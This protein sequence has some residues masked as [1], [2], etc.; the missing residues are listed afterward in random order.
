MDEN[1]ISLTASRLGVKDSQVKATLELLEE[2]STIPFIARYRKEVTGNLDEEQI[3]SISE[4]Y[5]YELKLQTRKEEVKRLIKEKDKLTD[6]IAKA[7]DECKMLSEVEDIYLPY[8][9]KKK[10][11]ATTAISYG[12][13]PL[14]DFLLECKNKDVEQEA[15]KYLNENVKDIESALNGA[16]DI[17]AERISEEKDYRQALREN[18]NKYGF[19]VSSIKKNAVDEKGLYSLYYDKKELIKYAPSHRIL[20]MN[21]GENEGILKVKLEHDSEK[22]LTYNV[23]RNAIKNINASEAKY[24]KEAIDDGYSRLLFPSIEREIRSDLLEKASDQS[25]SVFALNLEQLLLTPPLKNRVVLGFDPAYRTGCKL[26]VVGVNGDFIYKDVIYPHKKN[27]NEVVSEERILASEKKIVDIVNKYN[28]E[29]IAIG[30]GTAS[31]ESEEFVSKVINKHGLKCAYVITNEAGASVYSASIEAKNEFPDLHVEERSAISIARR[32]MDP[33]SELIKIDPK[34]IGVGQY[35]HDVNQPKLQDALD[36]T[37][38]K[39]V[40]NVGVNVNTAS[41]ELLSYVSGLNKKSAKNLVEYRSKQGLI[42]DRKEI[43]KVKGIGEKTY[44]QAIGFL[45]IYESENPLD[46]TFIH[47]DNYESVENLLTKISLNSSDIGSERLNDVLSNYSLSDLEKNTDLGSYTLSDVV[48]ELKKPLR[49]IRDNYPTP[50][51]RSDVLHI[52]DL[53]I[54]DELEGTIRSV[55]DFGAFVD[56]GLHNDGM[57]HKSK[58]SNNKIGHPLDVVSVGDIV[59][60][61][62]ID[63]DIKKERVGLSLVKGLF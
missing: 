22:Y 32:V 58:M 4:V 41:V 42:K 31:R 55:V 34:S 13:E 19:I 39:V 37:I 48:E 51:L 28:V 12:L 47:P 3:R 20:A 54:G 1:L 36:F 2:G 27:E 16:K 40:N 56:I 21:R 62:V 5:T 23:Y 43:A 61:Y 50:T 26:A 29:L 24:V 8:K 49:D 33:L 44:T 25:I 35:Q 52:E 9:E 63:I 45:K 38:T 11:R 7:I 17:I 18:L 30:N 57:I 10:T 15:K 14:A 59:K 60:V 6:E 53:H 46:K